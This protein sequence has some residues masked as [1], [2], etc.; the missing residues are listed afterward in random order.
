MTLWARACLRPSVSSPNIISRGPRPASWRGTPALIAS[1]FHG[2]VTLVELGSGTATKTRLLLDAF[3]KGQRAVRYVPIDI[4]P[5]VLQSSAAALL[6]RYP[7]LE[8]VAVAAEYHEGL[9]Q[10]RTESDRP[11][12][13]LWLGSNI[14]NFERTDAAPFCAACATA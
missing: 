10:L 14:G 13:I 7:T 12:L 2:D 6:E 11:K 4:C 5:S 9:E 1:G 8:I 3:L